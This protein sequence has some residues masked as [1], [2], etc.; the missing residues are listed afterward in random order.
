[1]GDN[2]YFVPGARYA[3]GFAG[4]YSRRALDELQIAPTLNVGLQDHWFVV[5]YPSHD[6]RMNFG[7][8]VSGQTGRLFLPFDAAIGKKITDK[9]VVMWEASVPMIKDYPV[10]NFK[11]DIRIKVEF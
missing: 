8:P 1:M 5:L 6:V 4:D 9:I 10:Y 11:T 7:E 3:I 2:T